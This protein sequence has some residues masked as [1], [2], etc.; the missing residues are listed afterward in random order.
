VA[1]NDANSGQS[2]SAPW[3]TLAKVN[4]VTLNPG[5]SVLFKRGSIW[6]ESLANASPGAVG[7]AIT[8]ADYGTGPKPSIRGSDDYT[9]PSLWTNE[10]GNLWYASRLW[11]DPGVFVHDGAL[12]GRKKSKSAL[13]SPWDYWYDAANYRLYVFSTANPA[14]LASLLEVA[15]RPAF[16]LNQTWSYI[17]YRNLDL[18]HYRGSAVW[19]GTGNVNVSFLTVDVSQVA[20]HGLQFKNGA[21]GTVVSCTFTDWG[22]VDGNQY[23]VLANHTAGGTT[24]P[25]DV[26][27]SKFT[28]NHSLNST[29]L[30]AIVNG[31]GGWIRVVA[32]NVVQANGTWPGSM[33]SIWRPGSAATTVTIQDNQFYGPGNCGIIIQD[34]EVNGAHPTVTV[35]RNLISNADQ[36]DVPGTEALRLRGFTTAS[37]VT[38]RYNLIWKTRSGSNSHP[39]IW[40][41]QASGVKI[42][43]NTVGLVDDGVALSGGTL[44]ADVRNNILAFNRGYGINLA[45][46]STIVNPDYNLVYS[47]S[48]GNYQGTSK[49]AHDLNASP[50]FVYQNGMDLRLQSSSPAIDSGMNLGLPNNLG[51]TP[52]HNS[53]PGPPPLDQ[54]SYGSGWE[55]GAF[56][57]VPATTSSSLAITTSSLPNGQVQL[58]YSTTLQAQGGTTP[59]TWSVS[60]GSLPAGLTLNP[61]TGTLSGT[62]TQS[63]TYSFTAQ[64]ADSSQPTAQKASKSFQITIASAA[65]SSLSIV[66]TLLASGALNA[67]YLATLVAQGGT[68]PY[69]WSVSS[70]TLPPGLSLNAS[71]GVISGTP[72]HVGSFSST[73]QVTDSSQP[74]RQTAARSF[75]VT[76][77]ASLM[78]I[79]NSLY[80]AEVGAPYQAVLTAVGGVAPYTWSIISGTLPAGLTLDPASGHITGTPTAGGTTA[81]TIQVQDSST[82]TTRATATNTFV[83]ASLTGR[84]LK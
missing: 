54:N 27:D 67:A 2:S 65:N 23:A 69:T 56:V 18:R 64:V 55:R 32:R 9:N 61:S 30:G 1:G 63:G 66:T 42:F 28:L 81:L 22:V 77:N 83:S 20:G 57:Y 71:T 26:T 78:V 40:A 79:T 16:V 52:V 80:P 8:Y 59:Y 41:Y 72:S 76:I 14:S 73:I 53:L 7:S 75:T 43:N 12:G 45:A 60:S 39:G 68:S 31:L 58:A 74:T 82:F 36:A 17:T 4:S 35:E 13:A 34:L 84:L 3:K 5:D 51:L 29:N 50:Q 33:L 37:N 25:V 70:G 62:P 10:S 49:G 11:M 47:N 6:R 21:S 48:R 24:G 38:A 46:D 44:S 15:T 19:L